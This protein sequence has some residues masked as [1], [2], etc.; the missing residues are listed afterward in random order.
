MSVAKFVYQDIYCRYMCPGEC[1]IQDRGEFCN[2]VTKILAEKFKCD[3]RVISAGRP[4]VNGQAESYVKSMK[5]K[6]RALMVAASHDEL[7]NNWDETLMHLGL[8]SLR[9]DPA[10]AT[11]YAPAELLLGRKLVYPIELDKSNVDT[12]GTTLTQPLASALLNIHN[13]AFG[14]VGEKLDRHQERYAREYDKKHK[15]QQ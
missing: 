4:Q 2:N 3:V 5:M 15:V 8:Q 11:G 14:S 12:S 7:P 9:C 1:I 13:E 6:L 10:V